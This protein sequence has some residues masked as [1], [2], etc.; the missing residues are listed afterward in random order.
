MQAG[1]QNTRQLAA[2]ASEI[3]EWFTY[4][5][6]WSI[7]NYG[8]GTLWFSYTPGVDAAPGEVQATRLDA[9]YSFTD[10]ASAP[11]YIEV[12]V[13]AEAAALTYALNTNQRYAGGNLPPG[14]GGGAPDP[15]SDGIL[16]GRRGN[17]WERCVDATGDTMSGRLTIQTDPNA[18][19][20]LSGDRICDIVLGRGD[21]ARWMLGCTH[22]TEA[23]IPFGL[24][25]ARMNADGS[26]IQDFPF[27][28]RR[29][30]GHVVTG[31]LE[32]R[33]AIKI[34][35]A[36]IAATN[37]F[38]TRFFAESRLPYVY[39]VGD[40]MTG[41]LRI[42]GGGIVLRDIIGPNQGLAIIRLEGGEGT[43]FELV[44]NTGIRW[45]FG[46][47]Y[48]GS[49]HGFRIGRLLPG[50]VLSVDLIISEIDGHVELNRPQSQQDPIGVHELT[51]KAYVDARTDPSNP[52][53]V[54]IIGGGLSGTV[55]SQ[56]IGASS[57]TVLKGLWS[58][59]FPIDGT[60]INNCAI[61]NLAHRPNLIQHF[62]VIYNV[63]IPPVTA[64]TALG[65][66][67]IAINGA[68]SLQPPV[69]QA[70]EVIT[71]VF[72][73]LVIPR[74]TTLAEEDASLSAEH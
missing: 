21:Q 44:D 61:I 74:A 36:D 52:M 10:S 11:R 71:E 4:G 59:N 41:T 37:E 51:R 35:N 18:I 40:E 56:L 2:G 7:L 8:P 62:P 47:Y 1:R 69:V 48:S 25:F 20:A 57:L 6:E 67:S 63:P 32:V 30:D 65:S 55:T 26:A 34:E 46:A 45:V 15:P 23:G 50:P 60:P 9:G 5:F 17:V 13:H 54:S 72:I 12:S 42:S 43:L 3:M 73:N 19:F 70:N 53:T 14:G 58:A 39:R 31:D 28:I 38:I 22:F 29:G 16:Y 33:S 49:T 66:L 64:H 24:Y 27:S 68:I